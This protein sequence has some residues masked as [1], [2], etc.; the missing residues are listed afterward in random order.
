M[1]RTSRKKKKYLRKIIIF[2]IIFFAAL[3][4]YFVWSFLN[5][6]KE[7]TV[8]TSME[9]PTL[10]VVY[11]SVYGTQVNMMHGYLQDMGNEAVSDCITVLPQNRRLELRITEYGNMIS[12]IS[13]EVRSLDLEHFIEKTEVDEFRRENDS[14]YVTLPIQN[15]IERDQQYLLSIHVDTGENT[16]NYYTRIIWTDNDNARQMISFAEEFARKTFDYEQARSLT[17][18]LEIN[19]AEDNSDLGTVGIRSNFSQLTW[20]ETDMQLATDIDITLREFDGIMGAVELHYMTTRENEFGATER[21]QVV[22]EYTM[23]VGSERIYLMDYVRHTNQIFEGNKHLFAGKRISLGITNEKMLQ[24]LKSENGQYIAFTADRELWTYDQRRKHAVNVFSFRSGV[25]DGA[26]AN[27]DKHDIKILSAEDNGDIDFIVY[28]YMNRGRHEGWNGIVYYHYSRTNDTITERFFIPLVKT[29]EKIRLEL[30]ELC[31]KG[32]NDMLYLKQNNSIVAI[33]LKSLEMLDIASGLTEG[34]YAVNAE[35]THLAWQEGSLYASETLNIMDLS[36]GNTQTV[37]AADGDYIRVL[38][39]MEQ[40]LVYG[41]A[42]RGDE[43]ILSNCVKGLPMYRLEIISDQ[44]EILKEYERADNY[45]TEVST[46]GNRIHLNL[47]VKNAAQDINHA[48][49]DSGSD[50][51]I[52]QNETVISKLQYIGSYTST[53]REKIYYV[54]L[55]D[56]I[57]TTRNLR[58]SVPRRIS[59]ENTGNIE[60]AKPV[61]N[62]TGP[63]FYSYAQGRLIGKE[64]NFSR[65]V[66]NCYDGMGWV[67]DE[68]GYILY[69]RTDRE[70]LAGISYPNEDMEAFAQHLSGFTASSRYEDGWVLLNGQGLSLQQALYYVY[71]G[72]PVILYLEDMNYL[73]LCGYD[74]FNVRF[75]NAGAADAASDQERYILMG[76]EDAERFTEEHQNDF[77]CGIPIID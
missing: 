18:Y 62:S 29:Y 46:E 64:E 71:K 39:F 66:Q 68:N 2:L 75:Y 21:Y 49:L 4:G 74:N 50:T 56:E 57:K 13:Y 76:R 7:F 40:D 41:L 73:F 25:D 58:I 67:T 31:T 26:R 22:D 19:A 43:W 69:N 38:G 6:E 59:Y 55:D 70:A 17:T 54:T 33:D 60:L 52:Y 8:Y 1:A 32:G 20:A 37:S 30:S 35:Q 28:G 48:Y 15:L 14:L 47:A 51:I 65:A 53:D 34:S 27:Y 72:Y 5:T 9:E 3:I 63:Y 44:L 12:G 77:I 36:S 10:P 45:V 16:V 23:R 61:R 24:T 42:H 11:T